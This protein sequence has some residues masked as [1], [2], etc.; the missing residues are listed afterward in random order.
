MKDLAFYPGVGTLFTHELDSMLNREWRV[1]P[2]LRSLPDETGMVVFVSAHIPILAALVAL[3][4]STNSKTRRFT[5]IGVGLFLVF[6][7]L[8]HVLFR[9]HPAYEFSSLLSNLLIFGA[10]VSGFF[11]LFLEWSGKRKK[12]HMK[13]ARSRTLQSRL[14]SHCSDA[15]TGRHYFLIITFDYSP[16]NHYPARELER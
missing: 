6:H 2:I 12:G 11:Y 7:G 1:I 5:R 3:I 16:P 13:S 14:H 9:N 4:S 10:A 15:D 8:L